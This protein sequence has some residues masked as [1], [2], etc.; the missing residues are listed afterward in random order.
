MKKFVKSLGDKVFENYGDE[1]FKNN[2]RVLQS[3]FI[4]KNRQF[5]TSEMAFNKF[6]DLL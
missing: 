6:V 5:S 3:S 2:H 4:M 1:F